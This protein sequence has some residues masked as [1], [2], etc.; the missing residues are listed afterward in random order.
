MHI[1]N[2]GKDILIFAKGP[3]QELNYMLTVETK[4]ILQG[5]YKILFK[6]AL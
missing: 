6:R 3:T 5:Q 4:L 2:K 1:N